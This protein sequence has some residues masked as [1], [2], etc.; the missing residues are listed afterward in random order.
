ML[1]QLDA[2]KESTTDQKRLILVTKG[3]INTNNASGTLQL[4][5]KAAQQHASKGYPIRLDA[6]KETVTA[7][8]HAIKGYPTI[9]WFVDG[10]AVEYGGPRDAGAHSQPTAA[11]SVQAQDG[12]GTACSS[13]RVCAMPCDCTSSGVHASL[14]FSVNAPQWV[15][16]VW[17]KTLASS[18]VA[19]K[20]KCKQS[21]FCEPAYDGVLKAALFNLLCAHMSQGHCGSGAEEGLWE[22]HVPM[23][24]KDVWMHTSHPP[25]ASQQ[26]HCGLGA[27]E[28][29]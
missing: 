18:S 7:K 11:P 23:L 6:T 28:G 5:A 22:C 29:S 17:S 26:G 27:E 4:N 1:L 15:A 16:S 3:N 25:R 10:Q 9:K 8:Q 12:G 21:C 24:T 14:S 20:S 19:F 13:A 2:T